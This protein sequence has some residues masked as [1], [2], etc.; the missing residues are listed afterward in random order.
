MT[1]LNAIMNPRLSINVTH[2]SR[3]SPAGN[4][5]LYPDGLAYFARS[6]ET[7]N[8]ALTAAIAYTP[9]PAIAFSVEPAYF[10]SDRSAAANGVV[11]PQ[12][13]NRSLSVSAGMVRKVSEP[14]RG[15]RSQAIRRS[16]PP[17]RKQ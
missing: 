16:V 11:A 9:S 3:R 10:S 8:A 4:Y 7:G 5:T 17:T 12:R 14:S 2:N 1:T 6:D 13:A 15:S